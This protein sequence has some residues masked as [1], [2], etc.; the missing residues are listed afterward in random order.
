MKALTLLLVLL[1]TLSFGQNLPIVVDNS[2]WFPPVRNQQVLPNC[3]AFSLIYYLKSSI[4]NKK[5]N[6]DPKLEVNQFNNNF[7]WNQEVDPVYQK[8][9]TEGSFSFMKDQGCATMADFPANEQ[10]SSVQPSVE[11]REKALKFKSKRLFKVNFS[12]CNRQFDKVNELL[13]SLKDSLLQGKCFT[14]NI[15]IFDSFFK[16]SVNHNIY[17]CYGD[18]SLDSIKPSHVVTVVGYNDTIKTA[19][20]RGAFKIIDSNLDLANGYFY[21]DYNWLFMTLSDYTCYFLEEDFSSQPKIT[22]NINLSGGITGKDVSDGKYPFADTLINYSDKKFDF[23]NYYDYL[24]T[25]N[26]IQVVNL[27][28]NQIKLGSKVVIQP[29]NNLDGNYQLIS[30]LSNLSSVSDFKSASVIVFDPVAVNYVGDDG[31]FFYSYT[32]E[33]KLVINKAYLNFL[34]TNNKIVAIVK[35]L[36]DTTIVINSFYTNIVKPIGSVD[37][38]IY[39]KSCTSTLKRKLITFS[40][41]DLQS[42]VAPVIVNPGTLVTYT[43]QI[44]TYQFEATDKNSNPIIFSLSDFL[45]EA[46]LT[47]AGKLTFK[48]AKVNTYKFT[49]IASNGLSSDSLPVTL[50]VDLDTDVENVTEPD[51]SIK[52]YPNPVVN[53]L[54][55]EFLMKK[56][57]SVNLTLYDTQGRQVDVVVQGE[58]EAGKNKIEYDA[59]NLRTGTY[60]CRFIT[61]N[62]SKSSKFIKY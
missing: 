22:L 13:L 43:N 51:Y 50:R 59:S 20:G 40:I 53:N 38:W 27:N 32:R 10:S 12:D 1:S 16:M 37:P 39:V 11:I 31:K 8:S 49:V 28:N 56:A 24:Y 4:W 55:I 5:F 14:I 7:V 46:Q 29:L 18:V 19:K 57:G 9:N 3:T 35:E 34:G 36:P 47:S 17:S 23:L 60:I 21:L 30:D 45:P 62:F 25:G 41:A 15:L 54:N 6:R 58:Y 33:S 44:F 2:K 48:S 42:D 52:T 61:D 26:Q